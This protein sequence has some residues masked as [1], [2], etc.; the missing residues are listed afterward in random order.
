[1]KVICIKLMEHHKKWS[2]SFSSRWYLKANKT[3]LIALKFWKLGLAEIPK[4][5]W[6]DIPHIS[7]WIPKTCENKGLADGSQNIA[8]FI[9]KAC[10]GKYVVA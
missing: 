7:A 1:M 4:S 8:I 6:E 10:G 2:S 5:E 9:N 3:N